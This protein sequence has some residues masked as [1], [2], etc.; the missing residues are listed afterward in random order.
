MDE[1][2]IKL[3]HK[4]QN[5]HETAHKYLHLHYLMLCASCSTMM[6]HGIR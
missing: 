5:F 3:R 1:Q 4:L 2:R 6:K